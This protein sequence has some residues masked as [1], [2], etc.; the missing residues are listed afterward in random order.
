MYIFQKW[1]KRREES[2]GNPGTRGVEKINICIWLPHRIKVYLSF[3][4]DMW[5][6]HTALP[7][8]LALSIRI[9]FA[10]HTF[11]SSRMQAT[12]LF[13]IVLIGPVLYRL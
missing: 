13:V 5:D 1:K 11:F 12:S 8:S 10:V 3:C 2:L 9:S 6:A 7:P 4:V